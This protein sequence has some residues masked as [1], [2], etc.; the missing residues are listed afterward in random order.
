MF[1]HENLAHQFL[2]PMTFNSNGI[3]AQC[4]GPECMAWQQYD[5][6]GTGEPDH[7]FCGMATPAKVTV[8]TKNYEPPKDSQ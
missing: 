1:V 5:R 6:D 4:K 3:A 2:C 8:D 7:G